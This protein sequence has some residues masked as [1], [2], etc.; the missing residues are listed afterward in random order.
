[1][2]CFQPCCSGVRSEAHTCALQPRRDIGFRLQLHKNGLQETT[3]C[4]LPSRSGSRESRWYAPESSTL[5]RLRFPCS[6]PV[7]FCPLRRPPLSPLFPYT[8]LFRSSPPQGPP[9]HPCSP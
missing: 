4:P 7:F 2:N 9:P 3:A 5:L 6:L 1:M 8:T